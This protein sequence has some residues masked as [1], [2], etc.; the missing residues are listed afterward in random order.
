MY[1]RAIVPKDFV[2]PVQ[3]KTSR[4]IFQPLTQRDVVRDFD[5]VMSSEDFL[6]NVF[7]PKSA[8]P[9]GLSLEGNLA[10]LGWHEVEFRNR[11][12]FAYTIVDLSDDQTLGCAYVYPS[13]HSQ[14]DVYATCWVRDSE[15]E[16]GLD[17]HVFDSFRSWLSDKW[18]FVSVAFPGRLISW[19]EW[20]DQID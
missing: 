1:K 2:V 15:R 12:S 3:L 5:A 11:S 14:F 7:N 17:Q 9:T 4:C 19:S 10:D 18:P 8:W 16:T 13:D 6:R 20:Y